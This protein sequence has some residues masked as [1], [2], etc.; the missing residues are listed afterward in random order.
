MINPPPLKKTSQNGL[1][2]SSNGLSQIWI[3]Q[4]SALSVSTL[5]IR[6][7]LDLDWPSS[8][9]WRSV[10]IALF[11]LGGR[12]KLLHKSGSK[13]H[14]N[15]EWKNV[16]LLKVENWMAL[17][18]KVIVKMYSMD[19][20]ISPIDIDTETPLLSLDPKK[21]NTI[22]NAGKMCFYVMQLCSLS[23]SF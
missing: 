14:E 16:N 19:L 5:M 23:V 18:V 17:F 11:C 1:I 4:C 9:V 21:L 8:V 15:I 10:T 13:F 22:N 7:A 2:T 6:A 3:F 20:P 12:G